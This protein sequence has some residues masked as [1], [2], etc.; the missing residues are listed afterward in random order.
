MEKGEREEVTARGGGRR[1]KSRTKAVKLLYVTSQV[2][3]TPFFTRI[4]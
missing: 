3:V 1:M 2:V 4:K